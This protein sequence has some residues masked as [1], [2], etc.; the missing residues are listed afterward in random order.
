MICK[1]PPKC[2]ALCEAKIFY[3]HGKESS[4]RACIHIDTH[5]HPV[6][7]GDC[8]DS[9]KRI[10]ALIEEHVER[11]PQATHITIVLEA[12]KDIVGY[13]FL[14]GDND[15][16]RLLS[17]KELGH[18][19]ESYRKLNSRNLRSKVTSFKYLRRFGVMDGIAK[20]RGVS[21]WAYVQRNQFLRQSDDADKVFVFKMSEVGLGSG[22]DLVRQM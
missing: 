1:E 11:T 22:V 15:T 10:N 14:S 2:I 19:F 20:L 6:K 5:Q 18:V 3:V 4:Q 9:R 13:I 17:L 12:N 8:R 21:N 16:Q 7:V